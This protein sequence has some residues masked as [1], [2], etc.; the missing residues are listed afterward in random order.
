MGKL[1]L[2]KLGEGSFEQGFPVT[3]QIGN[4]GSRPSLEITGK[5]PKALEIPRYYSRWATAYRRLGAGYRLEAKAA[6]V[7]NVSKIENC[8]NAAALLCDATNAWLHSE[9]FRSIRDKFLEQLIPSDEV[10]VIVQTDDI[11]LR[12]LPWHL[13]DLCARYPKAEIALCA[14]QHE[15]VEQLSSPTAKVRILAIL[16]NSAGINTQA[17]R[18]LLE[19]LPGSEIS[20]LVEPQLKELNDQLWRQGW[21]ILFFA[22]HS[23]SGANGE[24]GRIYINQTDSLTIEQLKYALKKAVERGLKIAIFNSCDGLGLARDLA[25]LQITQIIVMRE[26]VPDPVAQEFLKS[27]LEAFSRGEPFYLAVREAR[28]RLQ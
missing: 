26:P 11:Q 6:Q 28:E 23:A 24:T 3:L 21:D 25:D 1:V 15:R 5:L 12:R 10:R 27:F 18:L 16:G 2:L 19:Q 9:S 17:D 8:R 13:W 7:T 14:L 20:F 22:G 4:D